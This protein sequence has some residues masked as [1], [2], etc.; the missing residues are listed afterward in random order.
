[1]RAI[2]AST[3]TFLVIAARRD[4]VRAKGEEPGTAPGRAGDGAGDGRETGV[5]R[6]LPLKPIGHDGDSVA[7]AVIV[8][9]KHRAGFE[10]APGRAVVARQAQ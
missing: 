6:A 7:L 9:N 1:V 4:T 5:G 8:A 10:L 3:H 2:A